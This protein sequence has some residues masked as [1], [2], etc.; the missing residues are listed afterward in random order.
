MNKGPIIVFL[1]GGLGNQLFQLA[2]ALTLDSRREIHLEWTLGKPRCSSQGLPDLM[3]FQLPNRVVLMPATKYST[4]ASKTVGYVLRSGMAP[5]AWERIR[6]IKKTIVLLGGLVLSVYFR[7]FIRLERGIGTGYSP[8]HLRHGWSFVVGYFQSFRFIQ[9]FDAFR[10]LKNLSLTKKN[11]SIKKFTEIAQTEKPIVVHFRFGD[12][13][14]E[15]SFGI[16]NANYYKEALSQILEVMP[17]SKIWVFS[18]EEIEARRV[19]PTELLVRTRWFTDKKF[20]SA[21]T[22]E[23]MRLGKS[24]VI[25]N[26]TFSWWGAVLSKTE[27]PQVICPDAWFKFQ[28]EPLDL[29]PPSWKRVAAWQ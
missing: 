4:F 5:K 21:E 22:L 9:N 13:K 18:D 6:L 24:Y 1:T 8:I 19:F 20:S 16:P 2:N 12:Y 15:Q 11:L 17:Q 7:K 10:D 23:L 14:M 26:S 3:D 28:N 25:A 27:N 29:I